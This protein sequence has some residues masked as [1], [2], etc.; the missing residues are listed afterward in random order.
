MTTTAKLTKEQQFRADIHNQIDNCIDRYLTKN[1]LGSYG[2]D[3]CNYLK[4][5][6][7]G[8]V[9]KVLDGEKTLPQALDE[10]EAIIQEY[11]PKEVSL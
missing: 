2:C 11:L 10:F 1:N 3:A 4:T 8:L 7:L 5:I 6:G 9:N